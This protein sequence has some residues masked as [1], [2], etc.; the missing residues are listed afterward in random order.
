MSLLTFPLPSP[1][2]STSIVTPSRTMSVPTFQRVEGHQWLV[3]CLFRRCPE[4]ELNSAWLRQGYLNWLC[5][6]CRPLPPRQ[7]L[8]SWPDQPC[9]VWISWKDLDISWVHPVRHGADDR[10]FWNGIHHHVYLQDG[11]GESDPHWGGSSCDSRSTDG[12]HRVSI[13]ILRGLK[14]NCFE[15]EILKRCTSTNNIIRQFYHKYI[16][17]SSF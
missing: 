17:S 6:A 4:C 3:L 15:S 10:P 8:R 12:S 14:E 2:T 5:H 7:V 11:W 13:N 9:R 16:I 1:L